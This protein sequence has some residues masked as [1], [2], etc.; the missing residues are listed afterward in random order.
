MRK[1]I[2]WALLLI[3]LLFVF[4]AR[5]LLKEIIPPSAF[6]GVLIGL[7]LTVFMIIVWKITKKIEKPS[8]D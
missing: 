8:D 3:A 6:S 1:F 7:G 2:R 5:A 4:V